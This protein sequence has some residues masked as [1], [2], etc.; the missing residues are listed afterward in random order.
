MLSRIQ[1]V[2]QLMQGN[3]QALMSM[4]AQNPQIRQLINAAGGDPKKAFYTLCQQRGIDPDEI[5]N[6][7]K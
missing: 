1:Q 3:P 2:K 7:L 5:L 6:A 4:A